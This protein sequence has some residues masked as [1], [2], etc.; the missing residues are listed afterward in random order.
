MVVCPIDSSDLGSLRGMSYRG[1]RTYPF[2]PGI[3]GSGT[4]VAAGEGL[5]ARFLHGR[6][7]ACS[8]PQP[9][10]GTWAEYIDEPIAITTG[11]LLSNFG[12][13]CLKSLTTSTNNRA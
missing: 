9:G 1:E 6:R 4:V 3:K 5:M 10:N 11:S 13:H 7:V 12:R 8:A 2:T